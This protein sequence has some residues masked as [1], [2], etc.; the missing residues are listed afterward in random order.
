MESF[1]SLTVHA[2]VRISL[3]VLIKPM[4]EPRRF[5]IR[6]SIRIIVPAKRARTSSATATAISIIN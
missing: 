2:A 4:V 1:V 3:I 5:V 6:H